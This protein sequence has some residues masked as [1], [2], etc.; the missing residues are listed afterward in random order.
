[1]V[2]VHIPTGE[3]SLL[4]Y[5]GEAMAVQI[6]TPQTQM[7]QMDGEVDDKKARCR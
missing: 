2:A 6:E 7:K 5:C 1:M 3:S 4:L